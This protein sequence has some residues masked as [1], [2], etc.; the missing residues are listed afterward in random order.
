MEEVPIPLD[1]LQ[2]IE[3]GRNPD[4][5]TREFVESVRKSNQYLKGKTRA[6][7]VLRDNLS[8]QIVKEFPELELDVGVI[9]DNTRV[10]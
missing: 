3:D 1:V 2:Y 10:E 8:E 9:L 4:V 5:Y 7:G 6:F